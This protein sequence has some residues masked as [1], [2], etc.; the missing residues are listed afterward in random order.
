MTSEGHRHRILIVDDDADTRAALKNLLELR[1]YE[2]RVSANGYVALR[3]LEMN[4]APC[5]VLLDIWMPV[6]DGMS[7]FDEVRRL[8]HLNR[9]PIV[10]M[11]GHA[12][13]AGISDHQILKKPFS[14]D[15]LIEKLRALD[16]TCRHKN[17]VSPTRASPRPDP[18]S[19]DRAAVQP[20][21]P[22]PE[23]VG[24]PASWSPRRGVSRPKLVNQGPK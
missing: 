23:P 20:S 17:S 16:Q 18:H 15:A 4:D 9:V 13:T 8:P 11:T 2:A 10:L 6:M 19:R 1:G 22:S 14:I 12:G 7:L 3:S 21:L 24:L 5:L